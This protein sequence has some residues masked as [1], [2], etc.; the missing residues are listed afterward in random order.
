[1]LSRLPV[2]VLGAALLAL[3]AA[4]ATSTSGDPA[5]GG[6]EGAVVPRDVVLRQLLIQQARL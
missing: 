3:L 4:C 1:M 5:R 2:L 6:S